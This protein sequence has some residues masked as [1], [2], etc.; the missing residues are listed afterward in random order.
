MLPKFESK[1]EKSYLDILDLA[2][3]SG[4]AA[5]HWHLGWHFGSSKN[6]T[7]KSQ[8]FSSFRH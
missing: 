7:P 1:S 4:F 3:P 2:T 8:R 6:S 5:D